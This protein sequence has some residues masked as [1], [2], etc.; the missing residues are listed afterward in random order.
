MIPGVL[1]RYL[2]LV[3]APVLCLAAAPLLLRSVRWERYV[4][5][6]LLALLCAAGLT[7]ALLFRRLRRSLRRAGGRI[8][9]RCGYD[10]S[11]QDEETGICPECGRRYDWDLDAL[12]WN[13]YVR[14]LD[15]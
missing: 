5:W 6:G 4:E 3:L 11:G 7:G 14:F 9:L 12:Q 15:S 8:C 1:W 2:A 10:L 13:R